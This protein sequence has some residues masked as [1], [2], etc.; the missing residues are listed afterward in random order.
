MLESKHKTPVPHAYLI[1]HVVLPSTHFSLGILI[2]HFHEIFSFHPSFLQHSPP[3]HRFCVV[4]VGACVC[5]W[6]RFLVCLCLYSPS[7]PWH[8]RVSL[9]PSSSHCF[10]SL[11]HL[12]SLHKVS[13]EVRYDVLFLLQEKWKEASARGG[14]I[15]ERITQSEAMSAACSAQCLMERHLPAGNTPNDERVS[16]FLQPEHMTQVMASVIS[17][18]LSCFQLPDWCIRG[19]YWPPGL[20]QNE[21]PDTT[22]SG[23][24]VNRVSRT[25]FHP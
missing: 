20:V 9:S 11:S 24:W 17:N 16:A 5:V 3:Y 21:F 19:W 7:H 23:T 18:D 8:L 4:C 10:F 6:E 25:C 15:V 2:I 14:R 1:F 22:L 12:T 13:Y